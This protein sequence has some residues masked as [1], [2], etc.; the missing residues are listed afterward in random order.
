MQFRFRRSIKDDVEIIGILQLPRF[1]P[2]VTSEDNRRAPGACLYLDAADSAI[3]CRRTKIEPEVL[4]R[5]ILDGVTLLFLI[6]GSFFHAD[7]FNFRGGF[8]GGI[9]IRR[10]SDADGTRKGIRL[11][12]ERHL[13]L[14][15]ALQPH[16]ILF[17]TDFLFLFVLSDKPDI[18]AVVATD[19]QR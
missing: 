18:F 7:A 6:T 17:I 13:L 19:I 5:D 11:S 2:F 3:R 9:G 16:L 1:M 10:R 4:R 8:H 14:A 12:R 15:R